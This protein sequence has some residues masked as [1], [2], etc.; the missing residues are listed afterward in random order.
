MR[1]LSLLTVFIVSMGGMLTGYDVGVISG[2]YTPLS[3]SNNLRQV[4]KTLLTLLPMISSVL[5]DLI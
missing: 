4:S 3:F 1:I 2:M 5:A